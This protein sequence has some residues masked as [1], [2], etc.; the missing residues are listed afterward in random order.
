[1]VEREYKKRNLIMKFLLLIIVRINILIS[2]KVVK[3]VVFELKYSAIVRI[4]Q[5]EK[6]LEISV[7][8]LY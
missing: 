4:W 8:L 7:F 6:T 5:K 1:M 2:K 3:K